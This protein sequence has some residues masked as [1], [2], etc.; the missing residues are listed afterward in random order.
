MSFNTA[1]QGDLLRR[2]LTATD[3]SK[4]P[5]LAY[6][7]SRFLTLLLLALPAVLLG[8]PWQQNV[9][10]KGRVVGT[11][12]TDRQQT[13]NTPVSGRITKWFVAEGSIVKTGDLLLELSDND[14][15]Y[16]D[17]LKQNEIA[18]VAKLNAALA[19]LNSYGEQVIAI[20]ESRELAIKAATERVLMAQDRVLAAEREIESTAAEQETAK[21]N[22]KRQEA[23]LKD[24]LTSQRKQELAELKVRQ[25]TAKF[26]QSQ[27]KLA[28][29]KRE[30]SALKSKQEQVAKDFNAKIN[31]AT[32]TQDN[33]RSEVASARNALL[34]IETKLARQKQQSVMAPCDG[35]ILRI[36]RPGSGEIVKSGDPLLVLIPATEDLAVEIWVDGND[37]PLITPGRHIRLQFEGWPAVQFAGWPSVAVGTFG[38]KVILVDS[39]DD[40]TGKFRVLVSPDDTDDDWP[41]QPY[42]RQGVRAKGWI[43]LNQ[44][45]LGY[46]LWRQL[47]GFPPVVDNPKMPKKKTS[48]SK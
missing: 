3:L 17:R 42:L 5:K 11:K 7:L 45:T 23:L 4:T 28:A 14:P 1:E 43:L 34:S 38:G 19:K 47:N 44:V 12:P 21:L 13:V 25:S 33:A 48:K 16:L 39:T 8:V 18:T 10:G 15:Y 37:M 41:G 31:S 40:G 30:E 29:T 35:T 2:S 26:S 24:G 32:A 20:R 36:K 22:L 9:V 6:R 46:E 27:A